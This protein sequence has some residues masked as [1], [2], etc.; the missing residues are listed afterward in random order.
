PLISPLP[1][2]DALPISKVDRRRIFEPLTGLH[3]RSDRANPS[4]LEVP[5]VVLTPHARAMPFHARRTA[6]EFRLNARVVQGRGRYDGTASERK[7]THLN[8]SNGTL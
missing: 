6:A 4:P 5:G 1:L 8:S 7:S 2:L 3:H